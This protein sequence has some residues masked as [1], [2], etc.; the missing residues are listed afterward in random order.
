[1][2]YRKKPNALS[3]AFDGS[4][5]LLTL[6]SELKKH[7]G[8]PG[9]AYSSNASK[10]VWTDMS[11][12]FASR[13]N[14][15]VQTDLVRGM[16][17]VYRNADISFAGPAPVIG[18]GDIRKVM[19]RSKKE[20]P[21]SICRSVI[22]PV[23]DQGKFGFAAVTVSIVLCRNENEAPRIM[24]PSMS[25]SMNMPPDQWVSNPDGDDIGRLVASFC[26]APVDCRRLVGVAARENDQKNWVRL[27]GEA[28]IQSSLI[29][30]LTPVKK[31][32]V[33]F[34][35][36]SEILKHALTGAE[37]R[38][39]QIGKNGLSREEVAHRIW[40]NALQS[41]RSAPPLVKM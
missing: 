7:Q 16:A 9:L 4:E 26:S 6:F 22:P 19:S 1:M 13:I 37:A 2:S 18:T 36:G 34:G 5:A 23:F 15:A 40:C 39:R 11:V 21:N 32:I 20:N 29:E 10:R 8:E 25:A 24:S 35:L 12:E 30:V 31:S 28:S 14:L 38:E 17:V 41:N 33:A 27:R 3:Q